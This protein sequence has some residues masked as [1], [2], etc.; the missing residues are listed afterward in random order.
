MDFLGGYLS[1]FELNMKK[2]ESIVR[3][4]SIC[5]FFTAL[6]FCILHV[7]NFMDFLLYTFIISLAF[8]ILSLLIGMKFIDLDIKKEDFFDKIEFQIYQIKKI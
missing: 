4:I 8:H 5:G 6:I 3:F 2:V 1:N 7:E